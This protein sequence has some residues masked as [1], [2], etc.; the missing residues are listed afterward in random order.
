MAHIV[1]GLNSAGFSD[2]DYRIGES[3]KPQIPEQPAEQITLPDP[4]GVS[5][6]ET[7]EDDFSGL[8]GK[9]IGA[10]LERRRE[11]AQTPEIAPKADTMLDVAAEV[12]KAYTDAIQQT[13]NDPMTIFRGRCG[14]K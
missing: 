1:K 10:E 13:G 8:D 6:P 9:S 3:A 11:H 2:K 5:E 14:I 7:A 12:E 4:Q